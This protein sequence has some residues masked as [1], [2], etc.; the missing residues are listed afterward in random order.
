MLETN[1]IFLRF[2]ILR[3][4]NSRMRQGQ[5]RM[6]PDEPDGMSLRGLSENIGSFQALG[7]GLSGN[8]GRINYHIIQFLMV[9]D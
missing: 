7:C 1:S 8:E 5:S 9:H 6:I 2:K 3:T 4:Q